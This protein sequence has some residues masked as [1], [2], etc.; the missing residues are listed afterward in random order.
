ME[1]TWN[2]ST[3]ELVSLDDPFPFLERG[4]GRQR[5]TTLEPGYIFGVL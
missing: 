1:S 5:E 3:L 4:K 2:V